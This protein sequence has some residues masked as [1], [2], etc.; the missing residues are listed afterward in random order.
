MKESLVKLPWATAKSSMVLR[1]ECLLVLFITIYAF[2][3]LG[4]GWI[5]FATVLIG[6]DIS[7]LGYLAN[8]HIGGL[9][10]NIGHSY[11]LPRLILLA[12]LLGGFDG[13]VL[14]ALA[15]NAHISLDRSLG[16]GLKHES[17]HLTH[18]GPIPKPHVSRSKN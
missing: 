11:I 9:V 18:L 13:L 15:W 7:L 3:E 17:F 2:H 1:I 10:Y 5:L 6:V 12:S 16:F 4:G 14:F 8:S